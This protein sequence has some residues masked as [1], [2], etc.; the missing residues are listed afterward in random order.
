MPHERRQYRFL[1][2]EAANQPTGKSVVPL[3]PF[4]SPL[5]LRDEVD[6]FALSLIEWRAAQEAKMG[7]NGGGE[8]DALLRMEEGGEEASNP[9][10]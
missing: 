3:A 9:A 8:G 4:I 10:N 1:T 7:N 5:T 6:V 2:L